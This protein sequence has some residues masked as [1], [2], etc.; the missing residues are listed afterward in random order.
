MTDSPIKAGH[1]SV[2]GESI[3]LCAFDTI[4]CVTDAVNIKIYIIKPSDSSILV[5]WVFLVVFST[6]F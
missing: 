2:I 1:N 6:I 3:K 4:K 5:Q